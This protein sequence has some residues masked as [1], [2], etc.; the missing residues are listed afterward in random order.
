[1]GTDSPSPDNPSLAAEL[2]EWAQSQAAAKQTRKT[3]DAADKLV[4]TTGNDPDYMPSSVIEA[5]MSMPHQQILDA[6]N[7]M[8]PGVM[9]AS[10]QAWQKN[11]DAAMFNTTGLGGKVQKTI[12][13][14][15][16]GATADAISRATRRFTDQMADMHNITQSVSSRIESAAYGAETVKG[17]VPSIPEPP[18]SPSVPGAENPATV[19]GHITAASDAEQAAQ[20]AMVNYYEAYSPE[21]VEEQSDGG[22]DGFLE[23]CQWASVVGV[24][25]A[26]GFQVGDDA[27]DDRA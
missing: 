11:A 19:I 10:A 2:V 20:R 12:S 16:R 6:V 25:D 7:A 15:W 18:G 9:H 22:G 17:A 23:G 26:P 8:Q 14:G 21:S 5:F 24:Q 27:F 13:S 3:A 4:T 1:M